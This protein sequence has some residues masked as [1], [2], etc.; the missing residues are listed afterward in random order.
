MVMGHSYVSASQQ[1]CGVLPRRTVLF[2]L[3]QH[4]I[5]SVGTSGQANRSTIRGKGREGPRAWDRLVSLR[6]LYQFPSTAVINSRTS[7]I[8]GRGYLAYTPTIVC[9]QGKLVAIQVRN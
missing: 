4:S 5:P 1:D 3:A 7:S 2:T 6:I 9:H 8:W